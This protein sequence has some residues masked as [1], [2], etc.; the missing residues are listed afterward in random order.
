MAKMKEQITAV[1]KGMN[2]TGE[3]QGHKVVIDEPA[4]AGGTDEG[5][6]PLA[7]LLV[8]LAGCENAIANFVAKEMDFDLRGIEFEINGELDP[9][10]MMGNKEVRPYFQTINVNA[11]VTTSETEERLKELQEKVDQRCPVY[12]TL[13]AADVEMNPEW[14]K[15]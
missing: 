11:T 8:S 7:T 2:T 10:G 1:S 4:K 15:A 5:A 6:N 14:V 9:R 3:A 12:Q 13:I